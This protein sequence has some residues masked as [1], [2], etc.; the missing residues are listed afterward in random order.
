MTS[1]VPINRVTAV[2]STAEIYSNVGSHCHIHIVWM[3]GAKHHSSCEVRISVN[4]QL[5]TRELLATV[6]YCLYKFM[7]LAQVQIW[8]VRMRR[9]R[10]A[11]S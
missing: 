9:Q 1:F 3:S 8:P 11:G 10:S 5:R 2:D 6:L 7:Y 4:H